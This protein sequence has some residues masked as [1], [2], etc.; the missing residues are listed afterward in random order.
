[1][2]FKEIVDGRTDGRTSGRTTEIEGSQKLTE[3]IVLSWAKKFTHDGRHTTDDGR[4]GTTTDD[5]QR[6][7][8]I[9]H[10]EHFVLRW[11]KKESSTVLSNTAV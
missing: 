1:M 4:R 10:P 8:T 7:L 2:L 9:A 6:P 3:H 11:A 5:G